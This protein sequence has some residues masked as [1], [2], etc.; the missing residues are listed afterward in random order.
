[1]YLQRSARKRASVRR[2]ASGFRW[3]GAHRA[4][5]SRIHYGRTLGLLV[6]WLLVAG[7][8]APSG[9]PGS[10]APIFSTAAEGDG[11][12]L[13]VS[14]SGDAVVVDVQSHSG[15]GAA[16]V[17]LVSG[18][19][20]ATIVVRLHLSGLEMFRLSYGQTVITAA[21]SNGDIHSISE[22]VEL[23][24]GSSRPIVS[25]DPLWLD[26]RASSAQQP[27]AI[28][29]QRG[30]FEIRL[31]TGLLHERQRSFGLRWIDFYR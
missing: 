12:D 25:G 21:V 24:D 6:A 4:P 14:S 29:L 27:P 31:P 19:P 7:C 28:P 22:S 18:T 16:T 30:Y 1:M 11:N 20:P 26:I 8:G 17:E 10:P 2:S 5:S 23:P 13:A 3:P 9:A 15:I